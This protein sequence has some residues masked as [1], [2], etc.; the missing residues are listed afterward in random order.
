M[1]DTPDTPDPVWTRE[2]I[3][4]PCIKLCVVDPQTRLCTGCARTIDE[5]AGW[6]RMSAAH[7]AEVMADL[8]NRSPVP[9]RRRGGRDGR[10]SRGTGS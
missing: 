5:I 1:T 4:S 10:M 8:P 9:K 6:A 7:R 3:D 2:T